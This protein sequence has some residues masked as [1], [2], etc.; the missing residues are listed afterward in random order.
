VSALQPTLI[1]QVARA[2]GPARVGAY[3]PNDT[4]GTI[5]LSA[6]PDTAGPGDRVAQY[7]GI[8]SD[9]KLGY[10]QPSI[11]VRVRGSDTDAPMPCGPLS[12]STTPSRLSSITLPGGI[13]LVSCVGTQGGPAYIGRDLSGRHEFTVNF[14]MHIV[15]TAAARGIG[16]PSW[17]WPS[18]PARRSSSRSRPP[19]APPAV[20]QWYHDFQADPSANSAVADTTTF[21]S[22]GSYE[23]SASCSARR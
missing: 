11:Q 1:E 16:D 14:R 21:D 12:G 18:S 5:F 19:T 6:L 17:P 20:G 8:E 9:A 13:W 3:S 22:G 4:T 23:G 10:D 2:A 7:G 15:N